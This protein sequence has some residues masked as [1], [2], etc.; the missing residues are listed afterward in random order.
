MIKINLFEEKKTIQAKAFDYV[1]R[2]NWKLTI[3][4]LIFLHIPGF[5]VDI[6]FKNE[7][8][9]LNE[10][11]ERVGAL[12][13]KNNKYVES[14]KQVKDQVKLLQDKTAELRAKIEQINKIT[15]K[16]RNPFYPLKSII[17]IIP[18]HAWLTELL[19]K[20]GSEISLKGVAREYKYINSFRTNLNRAP[21]FENSFVLNAVDTVDKSQNQKGNKTSRDEVFS[22]TGKIVRFEL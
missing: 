10:E 8:E 12:I 1:K 17:H 11:K 14:N 15:K 4:A 16:K 20:D 13:E 3:F 21:F 22:F 7:M 5:L 18:E 19:V 6:Y 2:L 9:K